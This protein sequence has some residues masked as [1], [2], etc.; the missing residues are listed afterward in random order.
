MYGSVLGTQSCKKESKYGVV[1]AGATGTR[2]CV[3][4]LSR[5]NT[6]CVTL[7]LGRNNML[8]DINREMNIENEKKRE[9]RTCCSWSCSLA[10]CCCWGGC[11]EEEEDSPCL[12]DVDWYI[13]C[14]ITQSSRH[15][16]AA[17]YPEKNKN[18]RSKLEEN[19]SW[20]QIIKK[21]AWI[22]ETIPWFFFLIWRKKEGDDDVNNNYFWKKVKK[23][24]FF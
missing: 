17:L 21:E 2:V 22:Q 15:S 24:L 8:I 23:L 16:H 13:T 10:F 5:R 12:L 14:Y 4:R 11:E 6:T 7:W 1:V 19:A 20:S 18:V 9:R 3:S